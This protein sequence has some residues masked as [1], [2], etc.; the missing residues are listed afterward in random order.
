ML[1]LLRRLDGGPRRTTALGYISRGG[2][3]DVPGMLFA[4]R[5]SWA[6]LVDAAA[7][8]AGCSQ[9][10]LLTPAERD[11]INGRGDPAHLLISTT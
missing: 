8:L 9:V 1:G 3:F 7:P 10:D 6:H 11:A 5:C 2:T 4:N